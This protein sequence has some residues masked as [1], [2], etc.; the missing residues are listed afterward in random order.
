MGSKSENCK[1]LWG[2]ESSHKILVWLSDMTFLLSMLFYHT[3]VFCRVETGFNRTANIWHMTYWQILWMSGKSQWVITGL[4]RINSFISNRLHEAK[5]I[6]SCSTFSSRQVW[7]SMAVLP[8]HHKARQR[9]TS[10]AC[11][12]SCLRTIQIYP[13]RTHTC[14]GRA[15]KLLAWRLLV[16]IWTL[17]LFP[18]GGNRNTFQQILNIQKKVPQR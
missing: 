6:W 2:C 15:C 3:Y 12:H 11:T 14:T 9:N 4:Y 1:T 13:E 17:K 5:C 16:R 7:Q 8:A 18:A 10:H